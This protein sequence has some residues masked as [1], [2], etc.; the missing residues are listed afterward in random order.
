[1]YMAKE[2]A[3]RKQDPIW[4]MWSCTFSRRRMEKVSIMWTPGEGIPTT[5]VSPGLPVLLVAVV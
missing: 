2:E 4:I 1:M 5:T 3:T